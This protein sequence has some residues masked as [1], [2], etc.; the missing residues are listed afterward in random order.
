MKARTITVVLAMLAVSVGLWAQQ[1]PL[2]GTWK[3]NLAKSKY[4]PG[5]V[6][7]S[8]TLRW[9]AQGDA[10]KITSDATNADGTTEHLTYTAKPDGKEYPVT[11][12]PD[13]D[14]TTMKRIDAYATEVVGKKAGKPTVN[15]RR[16]VSK[17]GKTLTITGTGTNAKGQKIN[18]VAVFD[19]Q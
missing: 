12:D 13:R 19:R 4:S 16:V 8:Q 17:D 2:V 7:K 9:E 15:F 3:L 11:G 6:P 14:S 10:L 1:D 5:P 18:N